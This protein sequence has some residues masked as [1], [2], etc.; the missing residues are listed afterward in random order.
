M[1]DF[2]EIIAYKKELEDFSE[3]NKL[4]ENKRKLL[5]NLLEENLFGI[6]KILVKI[7]ENGIT[8]MKKI[9]CFTLLFFNLIR[10]IMNKEGRIRTETNKEDENE[11]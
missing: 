11:E 4:E 8:D 2:L 7:Y 9:N 1:C 6:D 10:Y 5:T 3:F